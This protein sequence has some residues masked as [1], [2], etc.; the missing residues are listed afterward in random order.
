MWLRMAGCSH[1]HGGPARDALV[2]RRDS[3]ISSTDRMIG[4]LLGTCLGRRKLVQAFACA[5]IF[6]TIGQP[7][8]RP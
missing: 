4:Y 7:G 1:F 8:T 3:G 5:V 2:P 6:G